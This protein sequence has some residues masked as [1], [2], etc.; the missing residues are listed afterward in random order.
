VLKIKEGKKRVIDHAICTD[1]SNENVYYAK[2]K[3]QTAIAHI[4]LRINI[5][6]NK[7]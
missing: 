2:Y 4:F 5:A 1:N 6:T 7:P 3:L